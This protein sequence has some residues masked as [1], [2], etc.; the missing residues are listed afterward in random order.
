MNIR[1]II[2]L[3]LSLLIFPLISADIAISLL[4]LSPAVSIFFIIPIVLI[5]SAIAYFVVKKIYKVKINFFAV[6]GMFLLF[7]IIT[8]LIGLVFI[9]NGIEFVYAYSGGVNIGSF[10]GLV[11]IF[12]LTA[13]IESLAIYIL[14]KKKKNALKISLITSLIVNFVSYLLLILFA[15]FG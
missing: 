13:I 6:L 5:E 3:F 4:P 7:N 11:G 15:F 14:I 9:S 1:L 10:L 12:L 2:I 8:A